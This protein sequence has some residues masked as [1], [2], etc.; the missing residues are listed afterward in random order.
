MPAEMQRSTSDSLHKDIE[1]EE[2]SLD[3]LIG[4]E[5]EVNLLFANMYLLYYIMHLIGF[6][7]V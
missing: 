4:L 2:L 7:N 1:L 6:G 5:D 3:Q